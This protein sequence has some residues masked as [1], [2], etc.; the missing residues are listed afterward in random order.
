M[1]IKYNKWGS[2]IKF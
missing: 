1:S 2:I